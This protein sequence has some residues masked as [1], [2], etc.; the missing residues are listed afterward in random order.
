[1]TK[2]DSG[3]TKTPHFGPAIDGA[4]MERMESGAS[5]NQRGIDRR[6]VLLVMARD[7]EA[8][9]RFSVD[10]PEAFE[11]T[12]EAVERFKNHAKALLKVAESASVRMSVA[13]CRESAHH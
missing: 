8:L 3:N 7:S 4:T 5:S 11:E 10:E 6:L 2:K 1:M 13:D 12:R 9:A